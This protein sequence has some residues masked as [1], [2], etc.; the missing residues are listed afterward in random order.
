MGPWRISALDIALAVDVEQDPRIIAL[1][2]L[3][4]VTVTIHDRARPQVAVEREQFL[5]QRGAKP[6]GMAAFP[7]V[8]R[9]GDQGARAVMERH[10]NAVKL[11][12]CDDPGIL[13]D[14]DRKG[15]IAR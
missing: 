11:V 3:H 8:D 14:V 1:D 2:E 6:Y 4:R 9:R 7:L 5:A 10:R 13:F 12:E 15:D